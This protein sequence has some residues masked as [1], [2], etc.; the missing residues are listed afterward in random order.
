MLKSR[1]LFESTGIVLLELRSLVFLGFKGYTADFVDHQRCVVAFV[2]AQGQCCFCPLF[3]F[4]G[5]F[6]L[7]YGLLCLSGILLLGLREVMSI[8]QVVIFFVGL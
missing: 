4:F 8:N 2:S 7:L 1:R 5:L 6:R 3:Q